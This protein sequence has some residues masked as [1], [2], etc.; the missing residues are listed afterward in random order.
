MG[1]D[2]NCADIFSFIPRETGTFPRFHKDRST[3]LFLQGQV[4]AGAA[5]FVFMPH[6]LSIPG[7]ISRPVARIESG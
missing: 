5:T 2:D 1:T 6:L 4:A 3:P 7:S